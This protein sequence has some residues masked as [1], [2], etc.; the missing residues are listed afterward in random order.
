MDIK[1]LR[2][3][4]EKAKLP[5][6]IDTCNRGESCWC[7][8]IVTDLN[9]P[10]NA[11]WNEYTIVPDGSITRENAELIVKVMNALPKMLHEI[12]RLR[13]IAKSA[14]LICDIF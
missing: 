12:E 9:P 5:W 11:N 6:Y 2:E 14:A 3:L 7:R 13:E 1:R 10:E 8:L 4:C